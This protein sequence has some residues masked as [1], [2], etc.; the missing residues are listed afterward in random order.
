MKSVENDVVF[1]AILTKERS[2]KMNKL[3][4]RLKSHAYLLF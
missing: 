3:A 4:L 1:F 2:N